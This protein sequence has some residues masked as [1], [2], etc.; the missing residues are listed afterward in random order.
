[1]T[2][3]KRT[4]AE[5]QSEIARALQSLPKY[6]QQ[7]P[8]EVKPLLRIAPPKGKHVEVSLRHAK[9]D[10]QVKRTAPGDSWSPESGFVS[11]S[12]D[13]DP[14]PQS[15]SQKDEPTDI[16]QSPEVVAPAPAPSSNRVHDLILA[17]ARAEEDPQLGFVALKWFRDAYL[18]QQGYAWAVEQRDRQQVLAEAIQKNWILTSK[19]PNPK[20]PAYPVTTIRL[21]RPLGEVRQILKRDA[22][23]DLDFAPL[24]IAGELLSET[25]LQERR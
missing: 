3:T 1:M 12:Y 24:A 10:R 15:N 25:V 17:L 20:N 8:E 6:A 22:R 11:V 18:L 5:D 14:S 9:T 21:N 4:I 16:G 7:L 2:N 19:V 23:G 13:N